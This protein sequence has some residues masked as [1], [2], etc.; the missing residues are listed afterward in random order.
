MFSYNLY[1]GNLLRV[2]TLRINVVK[3]PVEKS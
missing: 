2:K 1:K 3:Q